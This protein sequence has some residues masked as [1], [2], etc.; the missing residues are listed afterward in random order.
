M[1]YG[2]GRNTETRGPLILI[3]VGVVTHILC[4]LLKVNLEPALASIVFRLKLC[5]PTHQTGDTN[6]KPLSGL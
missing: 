5:I 3:S 2:F 1:P 4:K 6:R